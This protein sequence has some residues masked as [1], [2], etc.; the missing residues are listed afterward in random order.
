MMQMVT[1][2]NNDSD[3][4][5]VRRVSPSLGQC[6]TAPRVRTTSAA[7]HAEPVS[8]VQAISASS[9]PGSKCWPM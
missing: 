2:E 6:R 8:F 7:I 4:P 5:Q 1:L 3:A 9:T